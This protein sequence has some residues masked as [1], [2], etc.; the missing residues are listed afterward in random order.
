MTNAIMEKQVNA[1]NESLIFFSKQGIS[2]GFGAGSLGINTSSV[3]QIC[4][5][6]DHVVIVYPRIKDL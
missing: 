4:N 3:C 1:L 5:V 6:I 2:S